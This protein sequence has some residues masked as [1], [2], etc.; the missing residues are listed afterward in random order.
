MAA[1]FVPGIRRGRGNRSRRRSR[2]A[3]ACPAS[4]ASR[5]SPARVNPISRPGEARTQASA[6]HCQYGGTF[7][8]PPHKRRITMRNFRLIAP[9][10]LGVGLIAL[11]ALLPEAHAALP[12][13]QS[14]APR[15]AMARVCFLRT[16]GLTDSSAGAAP[17]LFANGTPLAALPA[18]RELFHGFPAGTHR[19]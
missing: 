5:C 12:E 18:G 8:L 17:M 2:A 13:V 19:L 7:A 15:P 16:S 4:T 11:P 1:G 6:S 3:R 14:P 10:L 9:M